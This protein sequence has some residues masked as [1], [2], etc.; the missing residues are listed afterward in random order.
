MNRP[1]GDTRFWLAHALLPLAL[2]V[3]P[4]GRG[5]SMRRNVTF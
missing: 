4:L 1:R 2:F 3:P 5:G